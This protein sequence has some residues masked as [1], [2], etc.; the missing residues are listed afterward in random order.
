MIQKQ[1][2]SQSKQKTGNKKKKK[3]TIMIVDDEKDVAQT[4]GY[5]LSSVG[6]EVTTFNDSRL[7]LHEYMSNPFL[8][9]LLVLDIR[10]QHINGLQLYGSIK[11]INP[12]CRA[13]FVSCLDIAREVV[14]ILPGT[15]PQDIMHKPGKQG[16]IYNCC[17]N[18]S[19]SIIVIKVRK[20]R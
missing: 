3:N 8:Y 7:A 10:M 5:F 16:A 11:A 1:I 18:S 19:G 20:T 2:V 15:R 4:Y 9:D 13:I 14:S 17:E 12:D 6:Y